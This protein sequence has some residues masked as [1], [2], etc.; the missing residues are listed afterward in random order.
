[1][2]VLVFSDVHGNLTAL[3]AVLQAAG[4]VEAFW[5]LGDLVGY[6]PDPEAC[7]QRVRGL[8]PLV[9]LQ[10]NHDAA[11]VGQLDL[12]F[13]NAEARRSVEWARTQ[14][15]PAALAF[16]Q[17][18]PPL[19]VLEEWGVTLAHG[20]PQRPLEEY[21]LSEP[22][23]RRAFHA[24]ETPLAFVGHTHL[25]VAFV[26]GRE[27]FQ[28]VPGHPGE[29]FTLPPGARA[30]LNPGSVGQPRDGNPQAAFA[31]WDTQTGVWSWHRVPYDVRAVQ[32][33]MLALGLPTFHAHRLR[34]GR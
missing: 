11:V 26:E 25:P 22:A 23:V 34:R 28:I 10:G 14:L 21:L 29:T 9:C 33:R 18:R 12:S 3:E 16:L 15:S 20:S 7:V 4:P 27:G 2:R 24:L 6:G 31:L 19:V 32:Q 30:I 17:T 5:F 1:M 8:H 13:F